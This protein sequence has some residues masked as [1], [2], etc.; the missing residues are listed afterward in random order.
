[1]PA[2]KTTSPINLPPNWETFASRLRWARKRARL[3]QDQVCALV[4][5]TQGA[6]SLLEKRGSASEKTST[7]AKVLRVD[8]VWLETGAGTPE[9]ASDPQE[10]DFVEVKRV[11]LKLSAGVSGFTVDY[12]GDE[13]EPIM[14]R[15]S[16]LKARGL[17]AGKLY[18]TKVKGPSM[19][20][21][22][23]DGDTV[24]INTGDTVPVDGEVY[25]I[26]YEGEPIIKRLTRDNGSWWLDSDNP[27]KVRFPRKH[28][29]NTALIVGRIVHKQSERI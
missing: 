6:Y 27:D 4:G 7:L 18:A 3:T 21:G 14:F 16:W 23:H 8:A 13:G 17:K 11:D 20:N 19:E 1:M 29:G 25:A 28:C 9:I 24:V 5:M 15:N 22:L 10:D 12:L 2:N 26:N